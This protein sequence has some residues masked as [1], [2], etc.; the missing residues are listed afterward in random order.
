MSKFLYRLYHASSWKIGVQLELP[1]NMEELRD[2][3]VKL[4]QTLGRMPIGN[5]FLF[6]LFVGM[7]SQ[8]AEQDMKKLG[9]KGRRNLEGECL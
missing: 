1:I 6:D 4:Q 2:N 9:R 7:T 5:E 8:L 3:A